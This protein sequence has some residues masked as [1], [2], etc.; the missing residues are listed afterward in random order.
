MQTQTKI[1]VAVA[2][3]VVAAFLIGSYVFLNNAFVPLDKT[4]DIIVYNA[5]P[6]VEI[7]ASTFNGNIEIQT[8]SSSQLEVIFNVEAPKGH[9]AEISTAA[10]N[11]SQTQNSLVVDAQAHLFSPT[12][13]LTVNHKA[14]ILIKLPSTS[15]Y[16]LTLK[17]LNGNIIKPQLNDTTVDAS[18]DN[19]YINIKDD[20]ATSITAHSQNG[21]VKVSLAQGTLFSVDANT[22]N[23]QVSYQGI[24]LNTTTQTQTHLKGYTSN[25]AE[26]LNMT[27]STA[28]GNVVVEYFSK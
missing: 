11:M 27:L 25:G 14:D 5:T 23:G 13:E 22:A 24:A 19:G 9:L 4:Q 18:T 28:N 1:V 16:N 8:S 17:T 7:K 2:V 6:N 12:S 15:Q 20:N 21:N 10:P 3:V 26:Q